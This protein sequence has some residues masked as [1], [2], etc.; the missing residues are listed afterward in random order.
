[1]LSCDKTILK[2]EQLDDT[3]DFKIDDCF[4][5]SLSLTIVKRIRNKN[6]DRDIL[7]ACALKMNKETWDCDL[8]NSFV[9][10]SK[11]ELV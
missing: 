8:L 10:K 1:M 2:Q 11:E 4:L 9:M 6:N 3:T 5:N 7:N